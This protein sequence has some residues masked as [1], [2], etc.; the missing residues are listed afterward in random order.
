M[1]THD[2]LDWMDD[3]INVPTLQQQLDWHRKNPTPIETVAQ[4]SIVAYSYNRGKPAP[5]VTENYSDN[6]VNGVPASHW[7][8]MNQ[9]Q[10]A[11]VL[12]GLNYK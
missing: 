7:H 5:L 12:A 10:R 6:T 4:G 2:L 9:A 8:N 1:T 3:L 11:S